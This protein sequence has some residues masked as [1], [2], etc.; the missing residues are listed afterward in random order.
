VAG[1]RGPAGHRGR[2][3]GRAYDP[4]KDFYIQPDEILA[5]ENAHLAKVR[6]AQAGVQPQA[7]G[8]ALPGSAGVATA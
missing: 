3:L 7:D 4:D 8:Q 6:A 2:H 1:H 5:T